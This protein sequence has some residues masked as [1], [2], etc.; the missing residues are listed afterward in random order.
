MSPPDDFDTVIAAARAGDD[1]AITR[2][3]RAHQPRL[4]RVLRV[5]VGDAADDV[6]SQTWLEVVRGLRR[7]DGDEAGFRALL[8]TVARR[9]IADHRRTHR[10][11]PAIPTE[12]A[13]LVADADVTLDVESDVL[14]GLDAERAARTIAEALTPDQAEIVMLRVVAGLPA[15]E[16]ARMLGRS[17]GAIRVQQ[18]RA[19]KRLAEVLRRNESTLSGDEGHR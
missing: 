14:A 11:R 7:F 17:P 13:S 2:L 16:V 1:A 12:P 15:E 3:Y 8:F 10:R 4:L 19:L 6:A 9:R 5:E 18:H